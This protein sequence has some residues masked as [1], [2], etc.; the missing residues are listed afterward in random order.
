MEYKTCPVTHK[1]CYS[2]T[3][4][5]Y[6]VNHARRKHWR[7]S[8]KDIP[9]RVYLCRFCGAYHLT[10]QEAKHDNGKTQ[11]AISTRLTDERRRIK[12]MEEVIYR[13][14]REYK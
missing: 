8:I 12:R 10:K 4:A 2:K 3:D 7:N 6:T 5:Q 1:R 14:T 13:Y 11:N 9:K